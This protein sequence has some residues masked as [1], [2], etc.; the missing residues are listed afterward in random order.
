MK[1]IFTFL[2]GMIYLTNVSA[3]AGLNIYVGPSM[4]FSG[5]KI[6]TGSGEGHFGYVIGANARLNSDPMYFLFSGEFGTFDFLSNK[7]YKFVGGNDVTYTKVKIGLGFDVKKIARRT[8]I[9]TKFQGVLLLLGNYDSEL[10][11]TP[12]Y[13]S[14][15]YNKLND[16]AGLCT[17]LGIS[18][19]VYT[20]DL[21]YEKGLF[22]IIAEKPDSKLNFLTLQIGVK[23]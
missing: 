21:E 17:S 10:F 7:S 2:L 9:R 1:Y 13:L 16:V 12:K 6:V 5:D 8:Y 18:R 3:Q 11:K 15:G 20:L 23:F 19:G 4:A 14:N 22:N